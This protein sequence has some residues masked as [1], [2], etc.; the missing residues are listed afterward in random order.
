MSVAIVVH[1]SVPGFLGVCISGRLSRFYKVVFGCL[2]VG[3]G[4]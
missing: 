2:V 1:F 4:W 3:F